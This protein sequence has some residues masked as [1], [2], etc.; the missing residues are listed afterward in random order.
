MQVQPTL[1]SLSILFVSILFINSAFSQTK[2]VKRP[3]SKVG[4]SSVDRFVQ[5]S[6]DIY[7]KVYMYDEYAANEKP[8]TEDDIDILEEA[9][10]EVTA[11][12]ESAPDIAGDIKG[13]GIFKQGKATLQL[14]KAQKVL[15]Y[16]AKTA[17]ELLLGQHEHEKKEDDKDSENNEDT[18]K[19]TETKTSDKPNTEVDNKNS[20]STPLEV[21][22]KFD[23]VPGDKIL[24]FDD[25][26][27]DFV[28]DFPAQWNTNGIGEVV[29]TNLAEGNWFQLSTNHTGGIFYIPNIENLPEDYTI[30]FDVLASNTNKSGISGIRL[31]ISDSD[32]FKD[33][34]D[35]QINTLIPIGNGAFHCRNTFC[36]N[37]ILY[38]YSAY[39]QKGWIEIKGLLTCKLPWYIN[40]GY[41]HYYVGYNTGITTVCTIMTK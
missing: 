17:K 12:T 20:D 14:N 40:K 1:K 2:K 33:N 22:S 6:F 32:N 37:T 4:I 25:F 19:E 8:L 13:A 27:Q 38:C 28:G 3:K 21:Y 16:S 24:F 9:V 5:E 15:K 41:S 7:D 31:L 18:S 23:F 36:R 11:L 35:N 39:W 29:R 30:E 34:N 26:S 10:S